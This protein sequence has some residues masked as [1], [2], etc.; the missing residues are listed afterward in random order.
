MQSEQELSAFGMRLGSMLEGGEVIELVGDV[1]AGKTTLVKAIAVGMGINDTI[2]SPSYTLSQVYEAPHDRR[3]VHYDFYRLSDPGILADELA[4]ALAGP[5]VVTAIEWGD[6]VANVIPPDHVHIMITP[7]DDTARRL[8]LRAGGEK[9][10]RL[11][12]QL[13]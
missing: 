3:L 9:S 1:G 11:L 10:S 7:V 5:G 13:Q 4:E 12:E 2:G 6:I 8:T